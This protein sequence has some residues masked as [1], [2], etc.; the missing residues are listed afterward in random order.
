MWVS[1]E[2]KVFPDIFWGS[3]KVKRNSRGI[4]DQF[5]GESGRLKGDSGGLQGLERKKMIKHICMSLCEY[6]LRQ[7]TFVNSI[8]HS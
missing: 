5:Q 3:N 4:S 8:T 6:E 1:E 7:I 2:F